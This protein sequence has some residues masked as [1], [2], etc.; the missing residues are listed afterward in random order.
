M[1]DKS[2]W[3]GLVGG[4]GNQ[5]AKPLSTSSRRC[6]AGHPM[7]LD[8]VKCPYC[9]AEKNAGE[10][11]QMDPSTSA[12]RASTASTASSAA[13]PGATRINPTEDFGGYAADASPPARHATA[14]RRETRIDMPDAGRVEP[15][16]TAAQASSHGSRP[17]RGATKVLYPDEMSS[18]QAPVR[19][20]H[21][22]RLTGIVVTFSWSGLGTLFELHEG[23][24]YVGSGTVSVEGNRPSDV[25][26][27]EDDKLSSAHFLILCQREKYRISDCN[28]TNGTY[29]NGEQIDTLG[30]DLSDDALIQAGAT[31]F[32]FRKIRPPA[33]D[34]GKLQ[35]TDDV[36]SQSEVRPVR[37]RTDEDRAN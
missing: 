16:G 25:M 37:D 23:R 19:S 22:R 33:A 13:G 36:P 6:E 20:S 18:S 11:T 10:R 27:P 9:E 3:R 14:G 34:Q 5:S 31:L 1:S 24:N 35:S 30:I 26:V 15:V 12:T 28:S 8:W 2:L 17:P 4:F 29:V 21:G 7:A 32:T